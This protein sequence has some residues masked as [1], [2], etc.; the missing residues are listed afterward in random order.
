[1]TAAA[2]DIRD[3]LRDRILRPIGVGDEQW[4]IGYGRAYEVDGLPLWGNWGGGSFTARATARVGQLMLESGRWHEKEL[5]R[6]RWAETMTRYAGMPAPA[7]KEGSR[8]PASGLCWWVN[9]DGVW[10]G[11]PRDAFAGAGAGHQ[12]LLVVPSLKLVAVRNGEALATGDDAFWTAAYREVFDPLMK[13]LSASETPPYPPS[14]VIRS[15][16]FAPEST[17]R[18]DAVESDNW[19][20][21]WGDDDHQY[22]SYGDGHGFPPLT[23]K[24]LGQGFARI[25]GGPENFHGENIRTA[26]GERLGDGRAS[27]K[28]SGMLM[29]NGVLY[30]WVRNTGNAQLAWSEDH[31]R[32]WQWG[33]K[34][35]VSFGSPAFLNFGKNYAG[36]R[37]NYVYFYSQDGPSAYD[38]DDRLVMGRVPKGRIRERAAYE[39]F[40]RLDGG[41]AIWTRDIARR[42]PVFQ[43]PGH[44]QRLD[45]VYHPGLKRYLLALAYNHSGAWGIFDAPEPWGPWTTAF[46]TNDWGLGPTHGYRLPAKWIDGDRMYLIF[47]G[48]RTA[49]RNFDA[50]CVR[51]MRLERAPQ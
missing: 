47:S 39:F 12:L 46:H 32:T 1:V 34:L 41:R 40:E 11:V 44:C 22:T 30:A 16:V 26:T 8:A 15:I 2:G 35:D 20:I 48:A 24:K 50:F 43:W 9:H 49:E 13:T 23:E 25:T 33:F 4:S 21:T 27:P 31:A 37:D 38:I 17:I 3:A 29:V 7:R 36:A 28:A 10:A 19:P 51:G 5:V 45:A 18:R 6:Q 14:A 42:G